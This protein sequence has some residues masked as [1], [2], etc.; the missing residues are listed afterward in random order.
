MGILSW[1]LLGLIVGALAKWIMPGRD[2][3]GIFMTIGLGVAG[4]FVGGL[5]ASTLGIATAGGFSLGGI[6]VATGGAVL[7]L[8]GYRKLKS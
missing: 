8:F 1:L 7:L 2:P 4:A 6:A 3:G 5:I